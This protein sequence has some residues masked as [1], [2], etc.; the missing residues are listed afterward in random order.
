MSKHHPDR[1]QAT[2]DLLNG[3]P[4]EE[5]LDAEMHRITNLSAEEVAREL[6]EAGFDLRK[7]EADAERLRERVLASHPGTDGA[8]AAPEFEGRDAAVSAVSAVSA[9]DAVVPRLPVRRSRL[10]ASSGV[11]LALVACAMAFVL[12]RKPHETPIARPDPSAFPMPSTTI[13]SQTPTAAPG[14]P[15]DLRARAAI[16][17]DRESWTECQR[18]LYEAYRL[19]P[20]GDRAPEVQELWNQL[21]D[22]R[23]IGGKQ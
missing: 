17:C 19:D 12:L 16:E 23:P 7:V 10:M 4:S 3:P 18:L 20:K 5:E 22:H 11:A 14:S 6:E 2:W 9:V 1:V 15:A 8:R 13:G 21:G